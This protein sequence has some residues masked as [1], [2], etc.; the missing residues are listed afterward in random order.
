MNADE[1]KRLSRGESTDMSPEA[2]AQ[3]IVIA[4]Q[5]YD[6]WHF[7][8][9]AERIPKGDA[10]AEGRPAPWLRRPSGEERRGHA[11]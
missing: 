4:S 7:L 10:V 5:L 6:L 3:R 8:R 2:I 9:P 11:R 1:A